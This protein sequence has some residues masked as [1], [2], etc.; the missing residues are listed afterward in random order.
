ME[1][2]DRGLINATRFTA[3]KALRAFSIPGP[4]GGAITSLSPLQSFKLAEAR[5]YAA[6]AAGE[7]K[8]SPRFISAQAIRAI[9]LASAT[10]TTFGGR[11]SCKPR[12]H[13]SPVADRALAKRMTLPAPIYSRW[14]ISGHRVW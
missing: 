14:R 10:M 5:G 9:L 12:I 6:A 1:S 13:A 7:R 2:T 3:P 11:R 8:L 4:T